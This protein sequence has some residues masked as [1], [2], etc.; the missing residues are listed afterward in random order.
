LINTNAGIYNYTVLWNNG[1]AVGG[2]KSSF[3]IIHQSYITLNKP[4]DAQDDLITSCKWGDLIPL[5]VFVRDFEN[6]NSISNAIISYNWSS[7]TEFMTESILGLYDAVLDTGELGSLGTYNIVISINKTEY[8]S[9]NITLIINL[10]W[11]DTVLQRLESNSI[12]YLNHNSTIKFHYSTDLGGLSEGIPGATVI[13]N[14]SDSNQYTVYDQL[15]GYY[16]IE[17]S[18]S[19]FGTVGTYILEFS[20]LTPGY[21]EQLHLYHFE[22]RTPPSPE[23]QC[24]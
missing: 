15:D 20:F 21:E 12:I 18:T 8:I 10:E 17:F 13:A 2:I 14:F 3:I 6:N 4:N 19:D 23:G 7:G 5:R 16:I 9:S 1:T 22:I 24:H 11:V